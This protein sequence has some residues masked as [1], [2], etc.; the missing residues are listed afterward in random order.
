MLIPEY[1]LKS[2]MDKIIAYLSLGWEEYS[3]NYQFEIEQEIRKHLFKILNEE[4]GDKDA[5]P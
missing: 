4:L 2:I 1:K 3:I 5:N